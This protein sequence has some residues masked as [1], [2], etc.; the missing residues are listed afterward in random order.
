MA[1][2]KHTLGCAWKLYPK[3]KTCAPECPGEINPRKLEA[4]EGLLEAAKA[5]WEL[6]IECKGS[7]DG[8]LPR[9]IAAY[10]RTR[11]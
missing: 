8:S 6:A 4:A 9:A 11:N 1:E 10:E 2:I 5:V 3:Q 7:L